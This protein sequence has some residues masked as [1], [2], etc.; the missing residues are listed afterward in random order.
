MPNCFIVQFLL[1][2]SLIVAVFLSSPKSLPCGREHADDAD[3][4]CQSMQVAELS[5]GE[6]A[7]KGVSVEG[8]GDIGENP[9]EDDAG[10]GEIGSAELKQRADYF[11][12]K[13]VKGWQE[14]RSREKLLGPS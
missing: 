14:E 2:N 7:E 11:I 3:V 5:R 6:E 1:F 13:V 9:L 10:N 12:A 4:P 8:N